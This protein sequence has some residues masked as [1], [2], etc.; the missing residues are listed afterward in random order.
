V[1]HCS[2]P[3]QQSCGNGGAPE[4]VGKGRRWGRRRTCAAWRRQCPQG[5]VGSSCAA[6]VPRKDGTR[7]EERDNRRTA[8]PQPAVVGEA[9]DRAEVT[10]SFGH[11]HSGLPG[12]KLSNI[13]PGGSV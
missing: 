2:A 3:L 9:G 13:V 7:E 4:F 12:A 5:H 6:D 1:L 8:A 10:P 11:C